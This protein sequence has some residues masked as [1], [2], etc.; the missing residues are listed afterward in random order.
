VNTPDENRSEIVAIASRTLVAAGYLIRGVHRQ[1]SHIEFKCDRTSRL[2]PSFHFLIAITEAAEFSREQIDDITHAAANQQR[3][4]VF[5]SAHG[6][7]GEMNWPEF[8]EVLGGAVPP[9]RVLTADFADQLAIASRNQL[10]PGLSGEAWRLF[11]VLAADAFEFCLG[12]RVSRMGAHQRGKK[13]S[14]IV[15]PLP[16]FD[17]VVIDAKASADGFDAVWD[18]LRPLAEYVERQKIRQNGG[19]DVI[20]ALVLSSSFRQNDERLSAVAREFIGET[21]TPLCFMTAD[22][23]AYLV[24]QLRQRSDMRGAIRWKMIFSGGFINKDRL[25]TEIT[26]AIAERCETRES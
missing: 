7:D 6:T 24:N 22:M 18:S 13:V 12:R 2:G 26:A 3:E 10:P 14:D 17:V 16:D 23:L 19:G 25:E 11:E 5:V 8:L 4:P 20:A 21:R 15:A 9:W 1:P